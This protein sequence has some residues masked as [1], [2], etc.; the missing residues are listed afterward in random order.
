MLWF[1]TLKSPAVLARIAS[2]IHIWWRYVYKTTIMDAK[3]WKETIDDF[4]SKVYDRSF[5]SGHAM[6][7][8]FTDMPWGDIVEHRTYELT[9]R[10]S[11]NFFQDVY[12]GL[13]SLGLLPKL[14]RLWDIIPLSFVIDW[15]VNVQDMLN[16]FDQQTFLDTFDVFSVCYSDKFIAHIDAGLDPYFHT[17]KDKFT[18]SG[19][20]TQIKYDR[21]AGTEVHRPSPSFH[22]KNPT[23]QWLTATALTVCFR[24]K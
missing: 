22:F 18:L 15:F 11:S 7:S 12:S 10:K 24:V 16:A 4:K 2:E 6:D 17:Y 21:F 20:F 3:A 1:A 23:K 19:K 14:T 8:T 9:I 13:E 5:V